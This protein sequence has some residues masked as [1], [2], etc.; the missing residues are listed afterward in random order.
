[1]Q[2]QS[3]G[4]PLSEGKAVFSLG[5]KGWTTKKEENE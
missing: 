1:M 2:G 4:A 5:K 3:M